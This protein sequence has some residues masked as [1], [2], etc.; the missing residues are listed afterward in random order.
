MRIKGDNPL[1]ISLESEKASPL[2]SD[3]WYCETLA[4]MMNP[5]EQQALDGGTYVFL[6]K[7]AIVFNDGA[8]NGEYRLIDPANPTLI[9]SWE[10]IGGGAGDVDCPIKYTTMQS[11]SAI[12]YFGKGIPM[13]LTPECK[14]LLFSAKTLDEMVEDNAEAIALL[15]GSEIIEL[16]IVELKALQQAT[17]L[18]TSKRYLAN[19]YITKYTQ[20]ESGV[21]MEGNVERILF[22]PTS[23]KTFEQVVYSVD[24]PQDII[25]LD[26]D[27]VLCEDGTTHRIGKI[28]YREETTLKL[29]TAYDFRNI[30]FRRWDYTTITGYIGTYLNGLTYQWKSPYA[31]NQSIN[32]VTFNV[33]SGY[34]DY[35]TFTVLTDLT[36]STGGG[37]MRNISI[38]GMDK[39]GIDAGRHYNNIVFLATNDFEAGQTLSNHFSNGCYGMTFSRLQDVTFGA[40]CK[41][42]VANSMLLTDFGSQSMNLYGH[43]IDNCGKI[44]SQFRNCTFEVLLWSRIGSTV[45][46]YI[47]KQVRNTIIESGISGGGMSLESATH[48]QDGTYN[49]RVFKRE[50][51]TIRLSYYDNSDNLNI[52]DIDS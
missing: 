35:Y 24:Y 52:V 12:P 38:E 41:N 20:S 47:I 1:A 44:G 21:Y 18:D 27:N 6:Y 8:N 50:D 28:T 11:N 46:N 3:V 4:D 30:K 14:T 10:I 23:E 15:G 40:Q 22:T 13:M 37:H 42:M 45:G 26:I 9:D 29:D 49:K 32:G 48:I 7:K 51:G 43:M 16:T 2:N 19:D 33:G 17:N 31:S 25:Y 5:L 36:S 34:K 39:L